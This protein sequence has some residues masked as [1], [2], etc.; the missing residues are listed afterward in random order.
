MTAM[1]DGDSRSPH[2]DNTPR[3]PTGCD[4]GKE[5]PGA[6]VEGPAGHP[7]PMSGVQALLETVVLET[8]RVAGERFGEPAGA[9]LAAEVGRRVGEALARQGVEL[10][11]L[12]ADAAGQGSRAAGA[13]GVAESGRPPGA[14]DLAAAARRAA[15]D[16]NQPLTVILGYAALLKRT[17]SEALRSEAAEQIIKEARKMSGIIAGLSRLARGLDAA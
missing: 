9:A 8:V 17:E 10:P 11:P 3:S 2:G 14:A 7:Q 4:A 5:A 6:A 16:L 12:A 13:G 15:H 1:P